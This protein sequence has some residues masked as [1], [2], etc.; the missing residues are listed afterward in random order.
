MTTDQERTGATPDD[1]P[2]VGRRR[3]ALKDTLMPD[4][5]PKA[6]G[7]AIPVVAV[8]LVLLLVTLR[9]VEY[10]DAVR[11]SLTLKTR[12]SFS[13]AYGEAFVQ[14]SEAAAV[15]AE[16]LVDIDLGGYGKAKVRR[17]QAK[18]GE[19]TAFET[20]SLY[21]VRIELPADFDVASLAGTPPGPIQLEAKI[22]TQRRS[23]FDKLFGAFR[24]LTRDL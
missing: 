2:N 9:F 6:L 1:E 23:L 18:V 13:R 10:Q 5:P 16:Q 11:V 22:L 21:R 20:S 24:V 8:S 4:E 12:E 15:Q 7:F 19:I 3:R 17:L 14:Q